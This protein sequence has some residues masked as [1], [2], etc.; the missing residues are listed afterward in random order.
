MV[1]QESGLKAVVKAGST[2]VL[3]MDA[4]RRPLAEL[5]LRDV[6]AGLNSLPK[7]VTQ[8]DRLCPAACIGSIQLFAWKQSLNF[9]LCILCAA[10]CCTYKHI[11]RGVPS[12][13]AAGGCKASSSLSMLE[14]VVKAVNE[15]RQIG[16]RD[17]A[18]TSWLHAGV[19]RLPQLHLVLQPGGDSLG[20]CHG[21][22]GYPFPHGSQPQSSGTVLLPALHCTT[23]SQELWQLLM[24]SNMSAYP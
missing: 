23:R 19:C 21:A 14:S 12:C 24:L 18:L 15:Q 5:E 4:L 8:V 17:S 11:K 3:L 7:G 16:L 1:L 13:I 10:A 20:T 22:L 9:G 2:S 6:T